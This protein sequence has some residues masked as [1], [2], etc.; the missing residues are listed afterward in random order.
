[1]LADIIHQAGL[2]AK[3][4]VALARA[5][6]LVGRLV[7]L[8]QV[9]PELASVLSGGYKATAPI[10]SQPTEPVVR[11]MAL[12]SPAHVGWTELLSTAGGLL[13]TNEGVSTAPQLRFPG[14]REAGVFTSTTDASGN[15][16]VGGYVFVAGW[17]DT[18]VIV[19]ELWPV[20]VQSAKDEDGL[21]IAERTGRPT[22]SMPAAELFGALAVPRAAA[23]A[24]GVQ[25]TAVYA[26]GNCQPAIGVINRASSGCSQ[27]HA[28]VT[29]S[30]SWC[31]QW[32][33][34]HVPREANVDA[35]RLSHPHLAAAVEAD[36]RR[37]GLTVVRAAFLAA[38]WEALRAAIRQSRSPP[39][40]E[41]G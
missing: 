26:I 32:L 8:S 35:D 9:S 33:A 17:P 30:R 37:A 27:M 3:A 5:R 23:A 16:G 20:D 40:G 14:R 18:I 12:A 22:F 7:N 4:R 38:D 39:S 21:P 25:P 24:L 19:S 6:T 28:I 1:M 2:A 34:V 36:A 29:G 41:L 31:A 15:D 11:R 13:S 10:S